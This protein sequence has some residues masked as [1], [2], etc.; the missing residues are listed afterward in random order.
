M[1]T[2]PFWAVEEWNNLKLS[3]SPFNLS[4]GVLYAFEIKA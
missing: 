1:S 3:L 4:L 2:I